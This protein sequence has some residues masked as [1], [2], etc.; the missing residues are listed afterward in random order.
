V[1]SAKGTRLSAT[2]EIVFYRL[3]RPRYWGVDAPQSSF[4]SHLNPTHR[5]MTMAKAIGINWARLHDTG[6]EYIGW[7]FLEPQKGTWA[8]HDDKI[9][10]YRNSHLELLGMLS[11]APGWATS[12]G[13]PAK[14]YFDYYTEPT[15]MS[16]WAEYARTVVRH[17]KGVIGNYEIWNEPYSGSQYWMVYNAQGK[18]VRT[19]TDA[20]DF[21]HLMTTAYASAKSADPNVNILGFCTSGD[22]GYEKWNKGV[23]DA[24]G[25]GACDTFSYHSYLNSLDGFPGDAPS[26]A[27]QYAINPLADSP[28]ALG[29]PMWLSEGNPLNSLLEKGF[30]DITDPNVLASDPF[31]TSNRLARYLVSARASGASK[32]FLY[33]MAAYEGFRPDYGQWRTLVAAD[34]SLD[35]CGAAFST[36]AWLVD[37]IKFEK[38][39]T[40]AS[41]VNAYVFAGN[42]RSVAAI[43]TAPGFSP[44]TITQPA[45]ALALDL[46]GNPVTGPIKAGTNI[47]YLLSSAPAAKLES[48]LGAVKYYARQ[49]N[50]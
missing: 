30:Y 23:A 45:G 42:G 11:T 8:Y 28:R 21:G 12:L 36:L 18:R 32:I 40:L 10:A 4:G 38:T 31:D 33:S 6:I 49:V 22:P 5:A 37:G 29:K 1:E 43:S 24:G 41:G 44:H 50:P 3:R 19:A 46:F 16:D 47:V 14:S 20:Q 15:N 26:K 25:L 2:N 7:N 27:I 39:L 9:M 34:G 13:R 48:E 17:Y 35:P